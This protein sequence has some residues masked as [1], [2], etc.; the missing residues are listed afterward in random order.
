MDKVSLFYKFIKDRPQLFENSHDIFMPRELVESILNNVDITGSILVLFNVEFVISL[1]HTYKVPPEMITL[2]SDH[3]NKDKI[4]QSLGCKVIKKVKNGMK[5]RNVIGNPP[6]Q[7]GN[8]ESG[9]R[10]SLWRKFVNDAF[11]HV[12]KDGNVAIVCPQFPYRAKDLGKYFKNNTPLVLY[13]DV[14][15]YFPGVGSSIKYWIVKEGKHSV[16]FIVDG[17]VWNHGLTKDPT[18]HSLASSIL[19]KVAQ[20]PRFECKQDRGYSSTQFRNDPNEYFETPQGKSTYPIRHASTVKVCYVSAPTEGHY[21]N[22]V[23]MTF[24]GYPNFEYYDGSTNPIS[25]C[26]QMSGYIEVT[27][28]TEGLSLIALYSTKL[29]RFLSSLGKAGLRGVGSYSLPKLDLNK[30]WTDAEVYQHFSLTEQE[31]EY[32]NNTIK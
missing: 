11:S 29:Y 7:S 17:I 23:M 22:K 2:Y 27:N 16:D 15:K 6:Y 32:V 30:A 18:I 25:S 1:V 12:I 31:I 10:H 20:F 9:G 24:S 4:A 13:N 28:E 5:F 26:Y 3:K 19:S 21:K 14:S 8:G